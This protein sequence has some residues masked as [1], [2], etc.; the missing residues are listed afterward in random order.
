MQI[1][2]I[3]DTG[4]ADKV[5]KKRERKEKLRRNKQRSRDFR[6]NQR[7]WLERNPWKREE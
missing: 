6:R 1:V 7:C 5:L 3:K 2:C 4:N